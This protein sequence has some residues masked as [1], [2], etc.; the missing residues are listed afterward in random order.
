M[1]E[2][3][4]LN[5]LA[6]VV[7]DDEKLAFIF[8]EALKQA[9]FSVHTVRDGMEAM[10][11]IDSVLP[12]LVVLDLHLP[13]VSG[14]TILEHIRKNPGM[15]ESWVVISTADPAMAETLRDQ[16][17]FILIKPISFIQLRDLARRL[18]RTKAEEEA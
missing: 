15:S 3:L 4:P 1:G 7:E 6:M 13:N 11:V 14:V 12:I 17:D 2:T 18:R 10:R 9:G 8:T 16:A 5:T